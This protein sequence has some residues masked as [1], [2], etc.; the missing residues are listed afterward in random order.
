M[1]ADLVLSEEEDPIQE[2]AAV[3]ACG[4]KAVPS[5][6]ELLKSEDF[7]NPLSPATGKL[8]L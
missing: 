6:I 8:P 3:V 4:A 7:Y 2:I 1:V 5:L